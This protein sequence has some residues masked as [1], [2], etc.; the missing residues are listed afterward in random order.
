MFINKKIKIVVIF[1]FVC[2]IREIIKDMIDVGVNVFRINFLYVDYEGVKEKINIIRG[3]NEEFGYII[4][5]FG[6]LQGLKFRV[7]VMEEGIVVNDGDIFI[8][9]IAEDIVGNFKRV[10][11]KYQNFF[12]DVNS[13]ECILLDDGKFIFEIVLIDKKIEVV[14]KVIQGGELKFKKGVN[15]LNIKILL[16]VLIE[17]DIVDVIFVIE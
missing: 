11:M 1:G 14:V 2:G 12:N 4:V 16:L 9:I 15:L 7:G 17:K 5:I 13:G 10:F 6:D 8:F 3:L